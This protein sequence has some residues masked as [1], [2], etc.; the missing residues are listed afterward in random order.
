MKKDKL[1]GLL[2]YPHQL[3]QFEKTMPKHLLKQWKSFIG[4]SSE[5]KK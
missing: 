2:G 1:K 3:K 5:K 4:A